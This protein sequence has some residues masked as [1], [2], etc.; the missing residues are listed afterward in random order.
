ML[1]PAWPLAAVATGGPPSGPEELTAAEVF[2]V[3]PASLPQPGSHS[4]TCRQSAESSTA[5][6]D[7]AARIDGSRT[8]HSAQGRAFLVYTSHMLTSDLRFE[9]KNNSVH[10]TSKLYLLTKCLYLICALV[11]SERPTRHNITAV[12]FDKQPHEVP[13]RDAWPFQAVEFCKQLTHLARWTTSRRAMFS[14]E[15]DI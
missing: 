14:G 4:S 3:P 15:V 7:P 5:S 1:S 10:I 6:K 11:K 9:S 8:G 2:V 13:L 12:A